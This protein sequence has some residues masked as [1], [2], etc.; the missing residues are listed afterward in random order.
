MA[1]M[2]QS[3]EFVLSMVRHYGRGGPVTFIQPE[4]EKLFCPIISADD[5]LLEPGDLF[6]DRLPSKLR[7]K[8]P[9]LGPGEDGAPW[10]VVEDTQVPILMVNGASGRTMSEWGLTA[11]RPEDRISAWGLGPE[12]SSGRHGHDGGVGE[13]LLPFVAI[14]VRWVEVFQDD[15]QGTRTGMRPGVQ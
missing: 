14:R 8:A 9:H 3:D 5:H 10:W 2:T 7:D 4:P 11:S 6:L 13:P 1:T 15:R 12:G